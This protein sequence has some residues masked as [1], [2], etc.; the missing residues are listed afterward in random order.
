[1]RFPRKL[2]SDQIGLGRWNAVGAGG[3]QLFTCN[4]SARGLISDNATLLFLLSIGFND[5]Q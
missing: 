1:M 5:E 2:G 3:C 4:G